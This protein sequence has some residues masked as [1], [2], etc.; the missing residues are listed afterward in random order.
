MQRLY[1][2]LRRS[3][4]EIFGVV[5]RSF[6]L[7]PLKERELAFEKEFITREDAKALKKL[8]AKLEGN[9]MGAL[10]EL[11][12]Q[13][14]EKGKIENILKSHKIVAS[15]VLLNELFSWKYD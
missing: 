2:P 10:S 3:N 12:F 9:R 15:N 14:A 11:E 6:G 4:K 7:E 1:A 5:K 8:L 13:T